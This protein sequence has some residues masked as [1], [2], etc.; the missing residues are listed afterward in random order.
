MSVIPT[1]SAMLESLKIAR[2][3]DVESNAIAIEV[4]NMLTNFDLWKSYSDNAFRYIQ[5]FD[6]NIQLD[7][8]LYT[9]NRSK[10]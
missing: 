2:I 5:T 10:N 6:W 1:N 4:E 3:V 9:I 8:L 7:T